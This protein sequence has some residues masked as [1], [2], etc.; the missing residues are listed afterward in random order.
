[1][2]VYENIMRGLTEALEY[3]QGTL[4]VREAT[5][6]TEDCGLRREYDFADAKPNPYMSVKSL[7]SNSKSKSLNS[8]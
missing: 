7:K 8:Y 4:E 2:S 3:Q 1:M 6:T 5:L